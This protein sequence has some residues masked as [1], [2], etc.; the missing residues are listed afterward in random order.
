MF[1]ERLN[2]LL[3]IDNPINKIGKKEFDS[4]PIEITIVE[5]GGKSEEAPDF[6]KMFGEKSL[7]NDEDCDTMEDHDL[8][9]RAEI[10]ALKMLIKNYKKEK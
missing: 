3:K 7:T 8:D 10:K 4:E 2:K 1:R 5:K 6:F 9:P